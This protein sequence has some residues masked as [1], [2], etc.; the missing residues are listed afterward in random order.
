MVG[1]TSTVHTFASTT[2]PAACEGSFRKNGTYMSWLATPI[3][4]WSDP[5]AP[6]LDWSGVNEMPWS[7]ATTS[8][9]SS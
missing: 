8:V 1:R 5:I 7:A 4:C 3:G 2:S 6:R 9:T